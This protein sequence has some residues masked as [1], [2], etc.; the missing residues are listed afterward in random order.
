M[1]ISSLARRYLR[2]QKRRTVL[3]AIG[4]TMSVALI[5]ATGL[6]L[7]GFLNMMLTQRKTEDGSWHYL[8]NEIQTQ[9]LADR[10]K[11]NALFQKAGIA[12][13]D[14]A[15]KVG[16]KDG[17][18]QTI[19]L[20]EYDAAALS[21]M[22]DVMEQGRF[23]KNSREVM[24]STSAK[25]YFPSAALGSTLTLPNGTLDPDSGGG[26]SDDSDDSAFSAHN[27][28]TFTKKNER[29]FTVVGFFRKGLYDYENSESAVTLNPTGAHAYSVYAQIKPGLNFPESAKKAVADCGIK[30]ENLHENGIVEWMGKSAS[31]RIKAAAVTTFLILSA[32]ILAITILVI[33][34]SFT[35]SMAEQISQIGTLRCLGAAPAHI[36]GL[37]LSEG[38][39]IWSVS[40][41]IGL[42]AG[43]GV[44]ALI[45]RIVRSIDPDEFR[46]LSFIPS[47]WP[48][49]LAAAL[50]LAA[51][52]LS[53]FN[54][55]RTA[56]RVPMVEAVRGNAVYRDADIRRSRKGRL[57]GRIFGFSGLLAA[58]NIRRSPKRFRTTVI[59]VTASAVLLI[60]VGGFA[61][62]VG[63]SVQTA[64]RQSS[65]MD[66]ALEAPEM[67][68]NTMQ[69]MDEI[70]QKIRSIN[71]V[72]A[73]QQTPLYALDLKIPL[74]R[75]PQGYLET[76]RDFRGNSSEGEPS[77]GGIER[78][79][80][81]MEVSRENY[82]SLRFQGR[83]PTYDE[84]KHSGGALLCQTSPLFSS[85]GRFA[86]A[87][88]ADYRSGETFSVVQTVSPTTGKSET[89]TFQVKIAGILSEFP[90]FSQQADGILVFPEG[91]T[92]C[93][94]TEAVQKAAAAHETADS[95]V[96]LAVHYAK[97]SEKQADQQ[98]QQISLSAFKAGL[99]FQD[100][101]RSVTG[102][103]NTYRVMMIFIGGFASVIILISCINLFNTVHA[104][105]QT[106]R[107][108]IAMTR[109]VGMDRS[110]LRRMLLLECSLYGIIGTA[111]GTVIGLPLQILLLNAFHVV[112]SANPQAPFLMALL[113]LLLTSGIG[114]LSGLSSVR[115][116]TKAPIVEEIRA[117][118]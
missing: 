113:A 68:K 7:S 69:A 37:I 109:A 89:K 47:V 39:C 26:S 104:N 65:G 1:T 56:M 22:P 64:L 19:P 112:F 75:V 85:S 101:Y 12:A 44:M 118:D 28:G 35:I 59:S 21:M 8:V 52:L 111:W 60:T 88:F 71:G 73:V 54:P 6:L 74:H 63:N 29:T 66:C 82:A 98:I 45:V 105:L 17:K 31:T 53:A 9:E 33:R 103:K 72:A 93:F 50:S 62:S 51:V 48:Y 86:N 94:H 80:L 117:E 107:R 110:Q 92:A 106:R 55:V 97:G 14:T 43:T 2:V 77:S 100:N 30:Q 36:R 70:G 11:G 84:L 67:D 61:L 38:M 40:A 10:L 95:E 116:V 34:N 41:P 4:V 83:A 114:V 32:I 46:F 3:T 13:K 108:E 81:T 78:Q 42:L 25:A 99:E 58:K 27:T 15:L 91:G 20:C 87:A 23:P 18:D 5:A 90:W 96:M 57:L 24:L 79:L 115:R 16:E 102:M 76:Y 49:L